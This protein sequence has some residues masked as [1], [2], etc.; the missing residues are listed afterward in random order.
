MAAGAVT[1]RRWPLFD[2][3]GLNREPAAYWPERH[4]TVDPE[5]DAGPVLISAAYRVV[6]ADSPDRPGQ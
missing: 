6:P 5:R 3:E 1:V 2:V 4:L